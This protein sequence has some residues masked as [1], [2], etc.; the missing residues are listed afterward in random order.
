MVYRN[1]PYIMTAQKGHLLLLKAGNG[2]IPEVFSAIGGLRTTDFEIE[3]RIIEAGNIE[4][5]SW[6]KLLDS[7]GIKSLNISAK[8]FFTDSAS[9]EILR[10][11]A[12]NGL[13]RNYEFSFGN[14]DK[15][16]GPFLVSFY[17]R[18]GDH[19]KQEDY[20]IRLASAGTIIFTAG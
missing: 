1:Y 8:G 18:S 5:G 17:Q 9:E 16:A 12:F 4:S 13:L 19:D 15:F 14:N 20:S 2:A 6:R 11:N 10:N 3:N 7:T